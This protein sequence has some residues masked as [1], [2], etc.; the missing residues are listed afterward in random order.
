MPGCRHCCFFTTRRCPTG[1]GS[2]RATCGRCSAFGLPLA[3]ASIVVFLVGFVDQLVVGSVLGPTLLGFYVLAVNLAGWP[4]TLFSQPLRGVAP[5]MFARLQ[6]DPRRMR[7][8]LTLVVR[9]LAL[10]AL[11]LCVLMAVT[12]PQIVQVV[13][14]TAWLP[15]GEVLRWLALGAV[16]RIFGELSYDYLVVLRRSREILQVQVI[17]LLLLVPAVALAAARYG[18]GGAAASLL[19]VAG[20]V[21]VP[22]YLR[23]LRRAGVGLG[24]LVTAVRPA[25]LLAAG[26]ALASWA[27][28]RWLEGGLLA[29]AACGLGAAAATAAALWRYRADLSVYRVSAE[30]ADV[31]G[32]TVASGST[33][34]TA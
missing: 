12:A 7:S 10:A 30:P 4:V 5:A 15:A 2:T 26:V 20:L 14:G 13:Y 1:S 22:L 18:I 31:A 23:E 34:R 21:T 3:G 33:E 25:V 28:V 32:L 8:D 17:S 24:D 9:P 6:H 16:L 19:L 29:L 11:P 27:V